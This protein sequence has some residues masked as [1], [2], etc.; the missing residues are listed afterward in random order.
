MEATHVLLGRPWQYDR[1][2]LHDG[3]TKKIS[4]NFQ[5]HKIILKPLSF[6]EVN[7]DQVK[8]KTKRENE[9]DEERKDKTGIINS[10]SKNNNVDSY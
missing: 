10:C 3:H 2:I 1:K 4:L 7:E 8:M 6:K 5:G 9:K